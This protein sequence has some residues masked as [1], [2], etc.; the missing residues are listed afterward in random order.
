MICCVCLL[1]ADRHCI[2]LNYTVVHWGSKGIHR[3]EW[4]SLPREIR[5]QFVTLLRDI[6]IQHICHTETIIRCFVEHLLAKVQPIAVRDAAEGEGTSVEKKHE[7]KFEL[8]VTPQE[9]NEIFQLAHDGLTKIVWQCF[10]HFSVPTIRYVSY[11]RNLILVCENIPH[12]RSD[13]FLVL[14]DSLS[15]LDVS[16]RAFEV[17]PELLSRARSDRSG[18]GCPAGEILDQE[19]E[20]R[21]LLSIIISFRTIPVRDHDEKL[22][23]MNVINVK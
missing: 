18:T 9:Q 23:A 15:Q 3:I 8:R 5:L 10:P 22:A 21:C 14:I 2:S 7:M 11:V 20:E 16:L 12:C 17:T 19:I 6:S 13:M 1:E 4:Q